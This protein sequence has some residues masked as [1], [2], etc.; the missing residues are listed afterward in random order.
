[1]PKSTRRAP[2]RRSIPMNSVTISL[3]RGKERWHRSLNITWCSISHSRGWLLLNNRGMRWQCKLN[4]KLRNLDLIKPKKCRRLRPKSKRRLEVSSKLFRMLRLNLRCRSLRLSQHQIPCQYH[5]C[6]LKVNKAQECNP[7]IRCSTT[8][9]KSIRVIW[10]CK[11]LLTMSP[12]ANFHRCRLR[13]NIIWCN[14]LKVSLS[15]H[16]IRFSHLTRLCRKR[17]PSCSLRTKPQSRGR[18]TRSALTP[19][20]SNSRCPASKPRMCNWPPE[21]PWNAQ[22]ALHSSTLTVSWKKLRVS[23]RGHANSATFRI[24]SRL[25]LKRSQPRK[26]SAIL[27]KLLLR[28]LKW[29]PLPWLP[30][31]RRKQREMIRNLR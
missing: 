9:N 22:D 1:M 7:K 4:F 23:S 2:G 26:L 17:C 18:S 3:R 5:Q 19:T 21:T 30:A 27:L 16:R 13:I 25:S 15:P 14:P 28:R 20:C 6:T 8:N 24:G 10:A 11:D 31:L 12:L 29:P